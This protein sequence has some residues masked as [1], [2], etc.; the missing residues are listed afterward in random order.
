MR[1]FLCLIIALR[2]NGITKSKA[3]NYIL[4]YWFNAAEYDVV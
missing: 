3:S 1:L 2:P 4:N